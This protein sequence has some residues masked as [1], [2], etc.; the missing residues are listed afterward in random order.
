MESQSTPSANVLWPRCVSAGVADPELEARLDELLLGMTLE[1]KVGQMIQAEIAFVT[2]A[3]VRRY[4]LGAV[5]NGGGS[6]PGGDKHA[7]VADWLAL[8]D[9]FYD[10]SM[11]DGAGRAPIPIIWGTDAVHGHNNT[12]GATIFPHNIGL[13]ATGNPGLIRDV[14]AVTAREVAATGIDWAFAPTLAVVRDD[15]WGRTYEGFSEDPEIVRAYAGPMVEGLQGVSGTREF[16]AAGKVIAT[17][18]HFI[19]DGGAE[20]GRDQ[21]DNTASEEELLRIHGQGYVTALA[22]GAQTV[23]AAFNSWHGHKVHGHRYLLTGVLKEQMGFDGIVVTDW[24]GFGQIAGSSNTSAG[25]AINAGV[26]MLMAPEDWRELLAN[27]IAQVRGGEISTQRIDD[28]AR[29][30]LRVKLRAGLFEKGRP[31]ERRWAGATAE[32]GSPE[33]RALARRAVRESL[34]LLK[35]DNGILPLKPDLNVLVAGDGADDI[36]KQ[37]GGWTLSWQG[38]GNDNSDF[39]GATSIFQGIRIAV[40]EAGGRAELSSDGSFVDRPDVAIVVF[41]ENPYAEGQGD[42]DTLSYSGEAPADLEL[43]RRLKTAGIP[44][45]AVLLTGRPLWVNPEL[46]ACDAFVVAWLPGSE[47]DGVA[48]M[49]F[50]TVEGQVVHD[51]AGRLSFSWPVDALQTSV[52]R[53]D[54]DYAPLFP[55]GYGL[56]CADEV[57]LERLS[58]RDSAADIIRKRRTEMRVFDGRARHPFELC[59]GDHIEAMTPVTGVTTTSRGGAISV[60]TIDKDV[61]GAAIR[62]RWTDAGQGR[63]YFRVSEPC[64][65]EQ[66]AGEQPCLIMA[67]RVEE[68]PDSPVTFRL[69]RASGTASHDITSLLR[70]LPQGSWEFARLPLDILAGGTL[71][72]GDIPFMLTTRGAL[73]LALADVRIVSGGGVA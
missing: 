69:A 72:R 1:Q 41:G 45:V 68:L 44:V 71:S 5:L 62:V 3:D 11:D 4:H 2:P 9:G 24:N 39:P 25:H 19:G 16:L 29:R 38:T 34:V 23:M 28:A 55:Y 10:A 22:A 56:R 17:A 58:E 31:S 63:I 48:D 46:N 73:C 59:I 40:A 8:A 42:R 20:Q 13:G 37:C 35:N 30:I 52:N 53:H 70:E 6:F 61:Q 12:F 50:G 49:L 32:L 26:D 14:A 7:S 65:L 47:G 60:A 36:G 43:L 51:F 54:A 27:T 33:H 57:V 64:Y 66:L 67:I 21:G 18:K 15:R